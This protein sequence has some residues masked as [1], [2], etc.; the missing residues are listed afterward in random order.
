[1]ALCGLG[2]MVWISVRLADHLRAALP[3]RE[4][5]R[6]SSREEIFVETICKVHTTLYADIRL[7]SCCPDLYSV[8]F[9]IVA[10][11]ALATPEG[12]S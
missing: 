10:T 3:P 4:K 11:S 8:K 9:S 7:V 2:S 1:M 12:V 5:L 6:E